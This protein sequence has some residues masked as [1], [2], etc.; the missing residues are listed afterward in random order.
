[1]PISSRFCLTI[2]CSP[3]RSGLI[4]VWKSNFSST[5]SLSTVPS[6]LVSVQPAS[7]SNCLAPST[8]RSHVVFGELT[9]AGDTA[10]LQVGE[11]VGP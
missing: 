4:E 10:I 1:M 6:P 7:A 3:W 2:A 5:P 9:L 8:S 11:P